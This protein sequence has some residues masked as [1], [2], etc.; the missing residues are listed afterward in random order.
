MERPWRFL[1]YSHRFGKF[2]P[3]YTRAGRSAKQAR[4]MADAVQTLASLLDGYQG[5]RDTLPASLADS[6][7][8]DRLDELRHLR[9]AVNQLVAAELP[10]G[11][12]QD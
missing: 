3:T 7:I 1:I 5:W 4:A 6:P 2:L 9:D 12:G 10:K 8:A 11:F